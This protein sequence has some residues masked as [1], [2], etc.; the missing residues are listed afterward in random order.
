VFVH[1]LVEKLK[2]K[3]TKNYKLLAL[4]LKQ[5]VNL[6]FFQNLQEF[7]PKILFPILQS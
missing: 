1:N 3:S 7:H 5:K 2:D 6:T 4:N